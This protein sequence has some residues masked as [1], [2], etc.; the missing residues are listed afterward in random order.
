MIGCCTCSRRGRWTRTWTCC[1]AET[2]TSART[3]IRTEAGPRSWGSSP[4]RRGTR[5]RCKTRARRRSGAQRRS[6]ARRGTRAGRGLN[7]RSGYRHLDQSC[8]VPGTSLGHG[9]NCFEL[10]GR[11][12]ENFR[13]RQRFVGRTEATGDQHFAIRQQRSRMAEAADSHMQERNKPPCDRIV[14]FGRVVV[15]AR[16]QHAAVF[17]ERRRLAGV[18]FFHFWPRDERAGFG[19][20]QL[21]RVERGAS[22]GLAAACNQNAAVG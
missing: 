10:A 9:W 18:T 12:I 4:T 6:R 8:Y 5:A 2:W 15:P 3:L 22:R 19:I 13:A 21:R 14:N 20:V 7:P 1:R 17:Q 16:D 11:R